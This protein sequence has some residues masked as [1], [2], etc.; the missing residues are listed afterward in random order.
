MTELTVLAKSID[1]EILEHGQNLTQVQSHFSQMFFCL[2]SK[3]SS[4]WM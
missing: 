2:I 1:C 3:V 4:P